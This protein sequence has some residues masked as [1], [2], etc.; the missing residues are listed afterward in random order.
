[1]TIPKR[2]RQ[3]PGCSTWKWNNK[4]DAFLYIEME[5]MN[6]NAAKDIVAEAYSHIDSLGAMAPMKFLWWREHRIVSAYEFRSVGATDDLE[7]ALAGLDNPI[8]GVSVAVLSQPGPILTLHD[9]G[10]Y[11][12]TVEQRFGKDAIFML[13]TFYMGSRA[14]DLLLVCYYNSHDSLRRHVDSIP[15]KY[16][17][18]MIED[19]R[20]RK[21]LE[22]EMERNAKVEADVRI[23]EP[24]VAGCLEGRYLLWTDLA[25]SYAS[26][27]DVA[28][29]LLPDL[30][31]FVGKKEKDIETVLLFVETDRDF[32]SP[33]ELEELREDILMIVSK[34]VLFPVTVHVNLRRRPSA[35]KFITCR[36]MLV[37]NPWFLIGGIC[38]DRSG[39]HEVLLEMTTGEAGKGRVGMVIASCEDGELTLSRYEGM[40]EDHHFFDAENTVRLQEVYEAD[41]SDSLLTE[42][43]EEALQPEN[44]PADKRLL[45]KCD[46]LGIRY[47]SECY[48]K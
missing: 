3:A 30:K 42:L 35:M 38:G 44:R 11:G 7:E 32:T 16:D 27:D 10:D 26:A 46:R 9:Q 37:G 18:L 19:G 29:K 39:A 23:G 24:T 31:R 20:N 13:D 15:M 43:W 1:M 14:E 12:Y 47:H 40:V 4:D 36:V 17:F 5:R 41:D 6:N 22:R 8:D 33:D 25:S 45:A 2:R 48:Y 34:D 21:V 28:K